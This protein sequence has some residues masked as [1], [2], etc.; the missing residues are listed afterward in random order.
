MT[1]DKKVD[2]ATEGRHKTL[3]CDGS[4]AYCSCRRCEDF[5]NEDRVFEGSALST[6]QPYRHSK[7]H[8]IEF[9]RLPN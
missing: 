8:G 4:A 5:D 6:C 9:N 3:G 1:D 2:T 7:I